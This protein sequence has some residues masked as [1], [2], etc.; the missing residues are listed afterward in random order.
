M[1]LL[2]LCVSSERKK[3]REGFL[4]CLW[5]LFFLSPG[6]SHRNNIHFFSVGIA[7]AEESYEVYR[8]YGF[9]ALIN[10]NEII[11]FEND[12]ENGY[13]MASIISQSH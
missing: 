12:R 3:E 6:L 4:P 2:F 7:T 8:L 5:P 13:T 10:V 11:S 9:Y 1:S